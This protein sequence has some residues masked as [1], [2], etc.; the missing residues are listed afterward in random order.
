MAVAALGLSAPGLL[1]TVD[2]RDARVCDAPECRSLKVLLIGHALS[3]LLQ[4]LEKR[5]R[6]LVCRTQWMEPQCHLS[7]TEEIR[8]AL[9]EAQFPTLDDLAATAAP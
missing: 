8:K 7:P 4:Q 2:A 6:T 1:G 9:A 3:C 5:L